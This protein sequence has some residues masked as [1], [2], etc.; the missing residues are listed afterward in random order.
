MAPQLGY[1]LPEGKLAAT[2][3]RMRLPADRRPTRS[4]ALGTG[5]SAATVLLLTACG[6]GGGGGASA[7]GLNGPPEMLVCR[8]RGDDLHRFAEVALRSTRNLGTAR[9]GD[10]TGRESN[11]R[12]HPD[13]VRVVFA[14]QRFNDDPDSRELYVS[15][16]DGSAAELRLTQNSARDDEPVWSPNGDNLIFT[17]EEN[18]NAGLWI[19]TD[20]GQDAQPFLP[21]PTGFADGQADWSVANNRVVFSRRDTTGRHVLWLVNGSG[22]GEIP[23]TD[24]GAA[25]G[26]GN[27]DLQP[28]FS[29]DGAT[30]AFVRRFGEQMATL[31]LADA[32]SGAVTVLYAAAGELGYP[33][34]SPTGE[35]VWFGLAEPD[36]GRQSLRLAHLPIAGGPPTLSWPDE[37]W[38]LYGLDFLPDAPAPEAADTAVRLN[39]EEATIQLAV[40]S[41]AFGATEQLS[42]DDDF[43]YYLSTATSNDRE[44]AGLN[45]R[46][47]LPVTEPEDVLEVQVRCVVR[48]SRVGGES[49]FR[50]SLRNLTDNR[51]DTVVELTPTSTG[52][53]TMEFRTSSLRHVA[54][55]KELQF[56]VIA[57][58]DEGDRVDFWIDMVEVVI[59]P[60]VGQ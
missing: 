14:R 30:I 58:I 41:N 26:T 60:R 40:A 56:N 43:E 4:M 1:R 36:S 21:T 47:N 25:V 17:S 50:I 15:T 57:D 19:S 13:G 34:L 28:A 55:E 49:V 59:V 22:F 51:Y 52:E 2:M 11:A 9:V 8:A 54:S 44:V 29:P 27:G 39:V 31:C 16:I 5:M 46:F 45:C 48:A 10:R 37:R 42:D 23:L 20:R 53:H 7:L 32:V 6:S 18:G 12:L 33:R 38:Q 24:G 35:R 3:A